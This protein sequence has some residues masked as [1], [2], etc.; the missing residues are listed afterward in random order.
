MTT[1]ADVDLST[2]NRYPTSPRL[3]GSGPFGSNLI[4]VGQ[5]VES[6]LA[7]SIAGGDVVAA[8][9]GTN[10]VEHKDWQAEMPFVDLVKSNRNWGTYLTWNNTGEA[11]TIDYD[12]NG[13]PLA[14][15]VNGGTYDSLDMYWDLA[16]DF[17]AER[18]ILTYDGEA[19]IIAAN[20]CTTISATSATG[21]GGRQVIDLAGQGAFTKIQVWTINPANPLKNMRIVREVDEFVDTVANPFRSDWLASLSIFSNIRHM[22]WQRTNFSPNVVWDDRGKVSDIRWTGDEGVPPEIQIALCNALGVDAWFCIPHAADDNYVTQF[23]TMVLAQL[24][25]SLNHYIEYSNEV[26]NGSFGQ[27]TYAQEQ[28]ILR[29]G[30]N[31][32]AFQWYGFR[33]DQVLGLWKAVWAG[34]LSRVTAVMGSQAGWTQPIISALTCASES[35][36]DTTKYVD[37]IAIAPYFSLKLTSQ[38]D[39]AALEL[40]TLDD[41]FSDLEFTGI[42]DALE[43]ID[44]NVTIANTYGLQVVSYEGGQ[45][46]KP[47]GAAQNSTIAVDLLVAANRDS[48]MGDMYNIYLDGWKARTS[49]IFNHW[50]HIG[51]FG[52]F[53]SWGASEYFGQATTPKQQALEN[54]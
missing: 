38:S 45:H 46:L 17:P 34:N 50:Y 53:G 48:R 16:A 1:V 27:N 36:V 9:L 28:S 13:W 12:A 23:A 4:S 35:S 2:W 41:V 8:Q 26:W 11:D 52:K 33:T 51:E 37:A 32:A 20:G 42:P 39:A 30:G 29:W 40:L 5:A 15:F 7:Q 10:L 43:N 22:D 31:E 47:G 19:T 21:D 3:R 24:D 18:Y 14:L 6:D 54:F 49:G 25:P 44:D